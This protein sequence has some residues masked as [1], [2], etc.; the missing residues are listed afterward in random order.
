MPTHIRPTRLLLVFLFLSGV[1]LGIRTPFV[2]RAEPAGFAQLHND[3]GTPGANAIALSNSADNVRSVAVR[4]D[5]TGLPTPVR[6]DSISLY[7]EPPSNDVR[8]FPLYVRI[9]AMQNNAPSSADFPPQTWSTRITLEGSGWYD[10]PLTPAWI[11]EGFSTSFIVSLVSQDLPWLPPP[12]LRLDDSSHIEV[13]RN[14]YGQRFSD[15]QEHYSF[16]PTPDTVG[17]LMFRAN[18]A[19]GADSYK[20]PTATASPTPT[21]PPTPA[22]TGTATP[23]PAGSVV[24]LGASADA[25]IVQRQPHTNFG[26]S[27]DLRLG[28]QPALGQQKSFVGG[29]F[30]SD[31][32]PGTHIIQAEL[33][34]QIIALEGASFNIQA[35]NL[36]H[37]WQEQT[38][39]AANAADLWGRSY[40]VA[41]L[42]GSAQIGDWL[43]W[44]VTDLVQLWVQQELPAFGIGLESKANG[45]SIYSISFAAHEQPYI[46]PRLRIRYM[47]AT[48]TPTPTASPTP[49]PTPTSTVTPTPSPTASPSPTPSF[50][51]SPTL[52]A[53]AIF[54]QTSSP[55]A[56][57]TP[58]Y[59]PI[60]LPL[61]LQG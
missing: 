11:I 28:Y 2:S 7:L 47:L 15:W 40:A 58:A 32:P 8:S 3:S 56:T 52:T 34:M 31:L 38:I 61:Q 13:N 5:L 19:T 6:I 25:T 1:I 39:N 12:L 35:R 18:V 23:L 14:F 49:S 29:F 50:T 46:G 55:T 16:W 24:E 37:P 48:A 20:T 26:H 41:R 21:P 9:E 54:T 10:V 33:A 60:Y 30:L 42:D 17:H 45:N 22:P 51:P 43:T 36:I 4:L 53:T 27:L 44:D 57:A 59:K